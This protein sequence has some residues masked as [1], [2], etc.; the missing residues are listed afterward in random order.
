MAG[1]RIFEVGDF[2]STA[3]KSEFDG[4]ISICVHEREADGS[5]PLCIGEMPLIVVE[6]LSWGVQER[7][8]RIG[9]FAYEA[10]AKRGGTKGER[11][12]MG[13]RTAEYVGAAIDALS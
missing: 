10:V 6:R 1:V 7:D 4:D 12:A 5:Y 2:Y 3:V 13:F 11:L 9:D 8:D